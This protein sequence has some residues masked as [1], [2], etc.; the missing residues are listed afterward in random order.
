MYFIEKKDLWTTRNSDFDALRQ[1]AYAKCI[2]FV[3]ILDCKVILHEQKTC[4]KKKKK[5]H[6][7]FLIFTGNIDCGHT[8]ECPIEEVLTRPLNLCLRA[9]IRKQC[10]PL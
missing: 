8:L 1:H 7:F 4:K 6:V 3:T 9:K 2:E 10:K 5:K